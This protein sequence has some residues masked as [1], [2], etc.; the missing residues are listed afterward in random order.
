MQILANSAPQP[1]PPLT[2]LSSWIAPTTRTSSPLLTC[3]Q[4]DCKTFLKSGARVYSLFMSL[5]TYVR[6][7][8][9]RA[10]SSLVNTLTPLLRSI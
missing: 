3:Q 1:V 6:L 4:I 10:S 7:T 5:E 9:F 2:V 8:S